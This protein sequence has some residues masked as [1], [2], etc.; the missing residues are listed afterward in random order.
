MILYVAIFLAGMVAETSLKWG[1]GIW[2][3]IVKL[4]R[5]IY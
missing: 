5:K 2:N 3:A 4:W 1:Q